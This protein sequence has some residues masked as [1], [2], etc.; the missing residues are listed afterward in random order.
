MSNGT[1]RPASTNPTKH[2]EYGLASAVASVGTRRYV[3]SMNNDG[4]GRE[5]TLTLLEE[6]HDGDKREILAATVHETK[7]VEEISNQLS[8]PTATAYRKINELCDANLL[9]GQ[10]DV[11]VTQS[12]KPTMY[13]CPVKRIGLTFDFV[14]AEQT[15]WILE[16]SVEEQ[17]H[18]TSTGQVK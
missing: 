9:V 15:S 13:A 6:I 18:S 3:H 8:I 11:T 16:S 2:I 1:P 12:S 4:D 5:S 17:P 14:A 7:T 10:I